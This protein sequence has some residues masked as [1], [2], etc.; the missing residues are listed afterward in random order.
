RVKGFK[1]AAETWV[2]GEALYWDPAGPHVTNVAG[3]L[4]LIGYA[5]EGIAATDTEGFMEF[6]GYAGF[7]KA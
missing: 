3:A 6:D 2:E 1:K 4:L 5:T 7:L